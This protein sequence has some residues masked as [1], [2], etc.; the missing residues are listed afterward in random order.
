MLRDA[1]D[2]CAEEGAEGECEKCGCVIG[3]CVVCECVW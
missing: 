2:R 1:C 3:L